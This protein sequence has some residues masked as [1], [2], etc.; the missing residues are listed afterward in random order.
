MLTESL[1]EAICAVR[2]VE[3]TVSSSIK[4]QLA[5]AELPDKSN[6]DAFMQQMK[7]ASEQLVCVTDSLQ[8][9]QRELYNTIAQVVSE[10][11]APAYEAASRQQGKGMFEAMK[12]S[13]HTHVEEIGDDMFAAAMERIIA[14]LEQT[15]STVVAQASAILHMEEAVRRHYDG[16]LESLA[17]V[18]FSCDFTLKL[19]R[20]EIPRLEAEHC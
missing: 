19:P 14:G 8:Q 1:T 17:T 2:E 5:V 9:P 13:L 15:I 16:I 18:C 20:F 12:T 6:S 11:M 7:E 10:C 3:N 4:G